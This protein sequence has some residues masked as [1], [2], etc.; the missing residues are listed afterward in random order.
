MDGASALT[1][2]VCGPFTEAMNGKGLDQGLRRFLELVHETLQGGGFEV[3]SAHRYERWGQDDPPPALIAKRDLEWM[4]ECA[5]SVMVL[6]TPSQPTW[7]T[8]G[9]F[10][11]LGWATALKRPIVVVGNLD[12]YRSPLVRGLPSVL[13]GMRTLAPNDVQADPAILLRALKEV[14]AEPSAT[15][16]AKRPEADGELSL[17]PS[18]TGPAV[19]MA[20]P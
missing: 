15:P 16:A 17:A 10:V 13:G 1:V 11:E 6:G 5:T 3:T 8:D 2:F 7:R 20:A 19:Q 4:R 9:T 12:A 14:L 18:M